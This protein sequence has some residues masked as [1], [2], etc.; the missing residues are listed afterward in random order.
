MHQVLVRKVHLVRVESETLCYPVLLRDCLS[1]PCTV[2]G[3][4]QHSLLFSASI[5]IKTPSLQMCVLTHSHVSEVS[6]HLGAAGWVLL[7]S[8]IVRRLEPREVRSASNTI[9]LESW[10]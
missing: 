9:E 7:F 8:F 10:D 2:V 4:E 6:T 3:S 1:N 5:S